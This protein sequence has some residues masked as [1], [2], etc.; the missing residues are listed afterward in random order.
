MEASRH[1]TWSVE[2][3]DEIIR[4]HRH[5]DG[6]TLPIL[7]ALQDVFGFVP[8]AAIPLI[9]ESLNLS[10]AEIH[11][12]ATFYH[13]FR[14]VPAGQHV[15]K[16]C[17]AEACQS[18]GSQALAAYA[19]DRLSLAMGETSPDGRITLEPIYCLGLC[20][21]APAGMFDG[22]LR[23]RLDRAAIDQMARETSQ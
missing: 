17:A 7:H 6:A 4:A 3:A 21:C 9:A 16:L 10:R 19:Q 2:R 13:D 8:E 20:A 23:G 1:E 15:V 22:Q 18:M 14:H 12:V 5:L 11:G